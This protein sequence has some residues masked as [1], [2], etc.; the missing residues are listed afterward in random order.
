MYVWDLSPR[1]WLHVYYIYVWIIFPGNL[2]DCAWADWIGL[3]TTSNGWNPKQL[4]YCMPSNA[5]TVLCIDPD[6]QQMKTI[7]GPLEG[8]WKW[9]GG[10]LGDVLWLQRGAFWSKGVVTAAESNWALNI[11]HFC[12]GW[13]HLWHPC[14][15]HAGLSWDVM[16]THL[17]HVEQLTTGFQQQPHVNNTPKKRTE[18]DQVGVLFCLCYDTRILQ[19]EH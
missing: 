17:G 10:N 13:Q 4:R 1:C 6:K 8:D 2:W 18:I 11:L 9:H 7:G 15:C 3:Q 5:D 19:L 16:D 12:W 14:K